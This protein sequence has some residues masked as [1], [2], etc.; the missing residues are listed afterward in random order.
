MNLLVDTDAF[1][2]LGVAALL[3]DAAGVF[4]ARLTEC[5]RL[6]ALPY[7][8]RKG[9]LVRRYGRDTCNALLSHAEAMP[10]HPTPGAT[11]L[12]PLTQK[13]T[14]DPGEAQLFAAAAEFG[15][16][17]ITGDKRAVRALKHV[18][19]IHAQLAGRIVTLEAVLLKLCEKLG[20]EDLRQRIRP[21]TSHDKA[22]PDLFLYGEFGPP[23]WSAILP[24]QSCR[25]SPPFAIVEYYR[26][27]P[28]V[29]FGSNPYVPILKVKRAEKVALGQLPPI[30]R[31]RITPLLEIVE[32]KEK[33]NRRTP[34]NG[35]QEP[36]GER[37]RISAVLSRCSRD[38][39][40]RPGRCRSRVRASLSR[41]NRLYARY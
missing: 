10:I 14:I 25:R 7:M 6:A 28:F 31:S 2:K 19:E 15:F 16:M 37:E 12:E 5:G 13:E 26:E 38:R 9:N 11:A 17:I 24:R 40:G 41:W 8:L 33:S 27:G 20:L 34:R 23:R 3:E 22:V 21:L 35:V 30:L 36:R 29:K 4:G 32:R 39:T 1:C 18:T